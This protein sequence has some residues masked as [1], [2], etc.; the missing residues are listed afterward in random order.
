[1]LSSEPVSGIL[2]KEGLC[3]C[4]QG[5][6]PW[7]WEITLEDLEGRGTSGGAVLSSFSAAHCLNFEDLGGLFA[8]GVHGSSSC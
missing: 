5:H 2:Q 4:D 8:Q 3:S 1:M 7:D 6:G